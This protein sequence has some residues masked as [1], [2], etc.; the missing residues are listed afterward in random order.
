LP[1]KTTLRLTAVLCLAVVFTVLIAAAPGY[2]QPPSPQNMTP[3]K[4][5]DE[6]SVPIPGEVSLFP[7]IPINTWVGK[8]FIFLPGPKSSENGSY[9]DFSGRVIRKQYQGR[10]AK[11]IAAN[12]FGG[13]VHLE[14]EMEETKEHLR[15]KTLPNK[16]SIKGIA[17]IDDISNARDRW[18]GKTLWCRQP[19]LST[20]DEQNDLSGTLTVKRYTPLKVVDIVS[21]WDEEKPVRFLLETA[22]GKR[23]FVDLNLSGTNVFKDF[24]QLYRMEDYFL[25]EDPHKKYK[26]SAGTWN[27]IENSQ[28]ITGM[29]ADQVRMSWGEPDRITRTAVGE[30]WEYQAG[31][32]KFKKGVLAGRL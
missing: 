20:Y 11:V 15:A 22:N 32:L 18:A 27:L 17:L 14:F 12:D 4:K 13:R 23:G 28:I 16:E 9:G 31:T 7:Y 1:T 6:S 24:R 5:A 25:A 19:R 3:N 30:N 8:R 10:I 26:W 21:G 2:A 29:T